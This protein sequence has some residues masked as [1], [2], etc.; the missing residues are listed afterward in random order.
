MARE[1]LFKEFIN[2]PEAIEF[3]LGKKMVVISNIAH[4]GGVSDRGY[5]EREKHTLLKRYLGDVAP[6]TLIWVGD[7]EELV[8]RV[9]KHPTYIKALID[10]REPLDTSSP[11]EVEVRDYFDAGAAHYSAA[12]GVVDPEKGYVGPEPE[13]DPYYPYSYTI[14][15]RR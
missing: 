9:G 6:D 3:L 13:P 15:V 12:Q 8:K 4:R 11:L 10:L 7:F 2:S 1:I 14:F 5:A